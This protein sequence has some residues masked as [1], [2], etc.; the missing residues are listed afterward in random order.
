MMLNLIGFGFLLLSLVVGGILKNKFRKFSA[1]KLSI[2]LTGKEIAEKMLKDNNIFDIKITCVDG[3]LTDHYN[4]LN[5]TV[6]L[7]KD[8][9]YNCSVAAAAVAAHECGHAV[10]HAKGY[11]FLQMRSALVPVTSIAAKFMPWVIFIGFMTIRTMPLLLEFGII[12][13]SLTTLFTFITLP[14]E[15]DAS[16]RALN[17]IQGYRIVNEKEYSNA[18]NALSW[19]AMTYVIAALGSLAQLLYLIAQANKRRD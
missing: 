12:L 17:W 19:A 11:A 3:E 6:N 8:V 7:S 1:E 9:Y 13:F 4:P 5:K 18:K 15:F 14:V 16:R 2:G 10:Q